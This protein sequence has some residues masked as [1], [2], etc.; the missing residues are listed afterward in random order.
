MQLKKVLSVLAAGAL[1]LAVALLIALARLTVL[2]GETP[3][4][5]LTVS[6]PGG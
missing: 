4:Q 1:R 3:A 2:G 6:G 5:A